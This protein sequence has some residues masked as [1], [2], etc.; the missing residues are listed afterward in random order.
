M[1]CTLPVVQGGHGYPITIVWGE[2]MKS[3][4]AQRPLLGIDDIAAAVNRL[5]TQHGYAPESLISDLENKLLGSLIGASEHR[6]PHLPSTYVYTPDTGSPDVA[7]LVIRACRIGSYLTLGNE[8]IRLAFN[9]QDN[10]AQVAVDRLFDSDPDSFT[11][12]KIGKLNYTLD[13][14]LKFDVYT[15][16]MEYLSRV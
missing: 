10:T 3:N 7:V 14:K 12:I 16:L 15:A 8:E 6:L 1:F 11:A 5:A 9:L 13:S 2:C 4:I